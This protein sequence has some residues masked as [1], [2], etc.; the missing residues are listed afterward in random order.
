MLLKKAYHYNSSISLSGQI[1]VRARGTSPRALFLREVQLNSVE[2]TIESFPPIM[3]HNIKAHHVL[4]TIIESSVFFG[5]AH[6]FQAL[7][8]TL[9]LHTFSEPQHI[10][11]Q[12]PCK[13]STLF[14]DCAAP[15]TSRRQLI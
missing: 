5:L 2:A 15:Y 11:L 3:H 9:I 6:S 10:L 4:N 1:F 13:V 7:P 12:F 14:E 8:A